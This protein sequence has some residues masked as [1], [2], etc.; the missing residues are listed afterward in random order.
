MFGGDLRF[1]QEIE[2]WLWLGLTRRQQ[3]GHE[4]VVMSIGK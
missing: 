2:A 4:I 3:Y 1:S